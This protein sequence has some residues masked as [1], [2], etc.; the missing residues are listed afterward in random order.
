[1]EK[2]V[3]V[4]E[5]R[6]IKKE[7]KKSTIKANPLIIPKSAMKYDKLTMDKERAEKIFGRIFF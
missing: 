7:V 1:M 5:I 2:K 3:T 4:E 6:R